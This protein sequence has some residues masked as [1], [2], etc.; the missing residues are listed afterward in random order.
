VARGAG[1]GSSGAAPFERQGTSEFMAV[2]VAPPVERR[3]ESAAERKLYPSRP[4]VSEAI[5]AKNR[6]TPMTPSG[7]NRRR[8]SSNRRIPM[9]STALC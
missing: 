5:A 2:K 6:V 3:R 4:H 1:G 8:S 7:A 9:M